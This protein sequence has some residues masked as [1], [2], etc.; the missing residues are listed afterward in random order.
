MP[1]ATA[2]RGPALNMLW[3]WVGLGMLFFLA[4]QLIRDAR[5]VRAVVAAMIAL[6]AAISVYGIYQYAIE[7]PAMQR[8]FAADPEGMLREAG[9]N[10]P[11]GTPLRDLFEKRLANREPLAT[12]ALTNSLAAALAPWLVVGLGIIAATWHDR[13]RWIAWVIC[14]VPIAVCLLLTKSRSGYVAAAV[15]IIWLAYSAAL[16]ECG[17]PPLSARWPGSCG[18]ALA[19]PKSGGSDRT[20][21]LLLWPSRRSSDCLPP[22]C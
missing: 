15:G 7:L 12:F 11:P 21:R 18:L 10:Y 17:L 4:R 9:L 19:V 14:L 1:S 22:R 16:A 3:E 13:R 5:E 6:M 8:Q 2:V 20:P